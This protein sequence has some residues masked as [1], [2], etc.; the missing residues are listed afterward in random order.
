MKRPIVIGSIVLL[1]L[2]AALLMRAYGPPQD[3]QGQEGQVQEDSVQE[4]PAPDEAPVLRP[5]ILLILADDLGNNDIGALGDGSASTPNIDALASAGARYRRHY[6]NAT[7]R[8]SRM[9]LLTGLPSSRVGVPPHVRGL[10]PELVTLPEA[11]AGSGYATQHIGKWHLGNHVAS[12]YP[13]QQGFDDWYGFLSALQTKRGTLKKPGSTY[14]NPWLQSKGGAPVKQKGHMTDLL[15]HAAVEKIT[16]LSASAQPWFIN[17]WYFAPH[18]PIQPSKEFSQRFADTPEGKY[19]ALVAQLDHSVGRLMQALDDAGV[20]QNTLVVFLSDNGGTNKRRNNNKPYF[21]RKNTFREGGVRT[22]FI[23][24][25]PGRIQPA[26]IMEPVFISDVMPTLLSLAGV[27]TPASVTGR[28]VLPLLTGA[29]V[30]RE[31]QYFWDFGVYGY[32][33]YGVLDLVRGVLV[34]EYDNQLWDEGRAQFAAPVTAEASVLRESGELYRQ[35]AQKMRLADLRRERLPSG[36]ALISGDSYRRTPGFGGWTLQLPIQI[37]PDSTTSVAQPGQFSIEI[38]GDVIQVTLPGHSFSVTA[39]AQGCQLLSLSSYYAW[40]DRQNPG[41]ETRPGGSSGHVGL[42][43]GEELIYEQKFS[44]DLDIINDRYEPM[45]L[46]DGEVLPAISNDYLQ[47]DLVHYYLQATE[48][49]SL[50]GDAAP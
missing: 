27:P 49:S 46:S 15:T 48:R 47:S 41:G 35:W 32:E 38:A 20:R 44:I 14:I 25:F 12:A 16:Q 3:S 5:N 29:A 33:K 8:P 21:G 19:L 18:E 37:A 9:A 28:S 2:A 6:A 23:L 30:E 1:L 13:D 22:P 50:C 7:C 45:V 24:N 4:I 43:L 26:D 40:S 42:Y 39:P 17:L 11:L 34:Y 36:G 10:T 31:P